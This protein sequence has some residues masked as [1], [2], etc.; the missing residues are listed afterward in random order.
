MKITLEQWQTLV[1]V[2]EAGSYARAAE[3]MNKSQSAISYSMSKMEERLGVAI[4]R[5]EGRRAV[6]T[7]AGE[8]LYNQA[9]NLLEKARYAEGIA[10]NY[11]AGSGSTIHLAMEIIFPV[12]ILSGVLQAYAE[13]YPFIRVE[14]HET[15]LSGTSEALKK[16]KVELAIIANESARFMGDLLMPVKFVAVAHPQHALH[17]LQRPLSYDDL[18]SERQI[19]I[20]DSGS[21]P[22]D[23]GWLDAQKRWTVS[24]MATSLHCATS[25]LG[26]AWYPEFNILRELESGQLKPLPLEQGAERIVDVYMVLRDGKSAAPHV[27]YLAQL[28]RDAVN[29][30][31]QRHRKQ[32]SGS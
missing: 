7:T 1:A 18:M 17:Q 5:I 15:A 4:F 8:A 23:A 28:I 11:Q 6:L 29:S 21:Q 9:K 3:L 22:Q 26:F 24:T 25:G 31:C 19:V 30:A 32:A 14:L 13:K 16:D 12:P 10:G 27:Q 2:V 20:R